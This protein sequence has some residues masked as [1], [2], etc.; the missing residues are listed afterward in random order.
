M[1]FDDRLKNEL[2]NQGAQIS[3][4]PAGVDDIAS[5]SAKRRQRRMAGMTAV[6]AVVLLGVGGFIASGRDGST[7][8]A[9]NL[10]AE[11]QADTAPEGATDTTDVQPL[12]G[13]PLEFVNIESGSSPGAFGVYG[14]GVVTADAYYMLSTAPGPA[15]IDDYNA[16][17]PNTLYKYDGSEW[18]N[19]SF[20]DRF[21][22]SLSSDQGVLYTVSTGTKTSDTPAIGSSSDGGQN[23]TWTPLDISEQ[24][25][26]DPSAWPYYDIQAATNDGSTFA[27]VRSNAGPEWEEAIALA[28]G[29]GVDLDPETDGIMDITVE[30]IS[31]ISGQYELS[32]CAA[33]FGEI[34]NERT[35]EVAALEDELMGI[36]ESAE[37]ELS[38]EQQARADEL[39][40]QLSGLYE[41]VYKEALAELKA[42]D[43]CSEYAECLDGQQSIGETYTGVHEGSAVA[44]TVPGEE[45]EDPFVGTTTTTVVS[46]AEDA[47]PE[48][49]EEID[50]EGIDREYEEWLETSGCG[51]ILGYDEEVFSDEDI[52]TVTWS[53]LGVAIPE[54]WYGSAAAY[55]VTDSGTQN[56]GR[57]AEGEAGWLN[58]I[59][60]DGSNFEA[61]FEGMWSPTFE[62]EQTPPAS[63]VYSS[64]DGT[65]W[66]TSE[67]PWGTAVPSFAGMSFV[68]DWNEVESSVVRN[69]SERLSLSDLA[70]NLDVTGYQPDR[71]FIGQYGVVIT[72]SKWEDGGNYGRV[73]SIVF[74]SSDGLSFGATPLEGLGVGSVMVG[75][76]GVVV[77]ADNVELA[78]SDTPQP[79]LFGT[80]S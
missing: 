29:A 68:I 18:T 9:T 52:Q 27:V 76:N 4:E 79:V 62:A 32:P 55:L 33:L 35:P 73:D 21:I 42:S 22:S 41:M 25:G 37:Y 70:P 69:G 49:A 6:A 67:R 50:F 16:Y 1:N 61:V 28:Q 14:T 15:D 53:E 13:A 48:A 47:S 20:G 12:A 43:G 38:D 8:V 51:Q 54:S 34:M 58:S 45:I 10:D 78:N 59:G 24:F 36:Y 60:F 11:E 19:S 44:T 66:T 65:T 31:W 80:A 72:A 26:A 63:T 5:R 40:R 30:G 2:Q 64:T 57:F 46:Q 74:F 77:F 56:L 39:D 75:V 17:R 3:I 71:I 23:W 7:P